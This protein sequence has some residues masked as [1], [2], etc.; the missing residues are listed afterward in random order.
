MTPAD[1]DEICCLVCPYCAAGVASRYR[2][3]TREHTHDSVD[4]T[5]NRHTRHHTLCRAN[6]FR[7][8]RFAK[9]SASG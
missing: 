6:G 9:E 5:P 1:F 8:S 4:G 7:N 2:V 3:S